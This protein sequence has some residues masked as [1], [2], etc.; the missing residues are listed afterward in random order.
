[1]KKYISPKFELLFIKVGDIFLSSSLNKDKKEDSYKKEDEELNF[2][3]AI[4][5]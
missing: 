3:D 2:F 4:D 5:L 1:M